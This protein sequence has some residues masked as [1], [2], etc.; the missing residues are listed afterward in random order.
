[1]KQSEMMERD[2]DR[3]HVDRRYQ[4]VQ[5]PRFAG[6]RELRISLFVASARCRANGLVIDRVRCEV[7]LAGRRLLLLLTY[8]SLGEW[9][10]KSYHK[11]HQ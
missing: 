3:L 5:T 8:F 9:R 1:M 4:R 2:T 6:G 10:Q 11:T 7:L